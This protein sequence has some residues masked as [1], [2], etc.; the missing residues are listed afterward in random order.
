MFLAPVMARPSPPNAITST[1]ATDQP[2]PEPIPGQIELDTVRPS[3]NPP[4]QAPRRASADIEA[5]HASD[6]QQ[7]LPWPK[8]KKGWKSQWLFSRTW[9]N[10]AALIACFIAFGAVFYAIRSYDLSV[11][12][13]KKDFW[14]QC[15]GFEVSIALSNAGMLRAEA[16]EL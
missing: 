2:N 16:D 14:E 12:T 5:L 13:A 3:S 15:Q 7:R 4:S 10:I 1:T 6:V 9:Q 11:W 8:G